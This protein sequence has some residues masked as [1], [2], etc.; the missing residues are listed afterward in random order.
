MLH[1]FYNLQRVFLNSFKA[2]LHAASNNCV[3]IKNP[4]EITLGYIKGQ[5]WETEIK[6][7][8]ANLPYE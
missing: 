2:S 8:K 4:S 3:F 5:L 1:D 6:L 7:T